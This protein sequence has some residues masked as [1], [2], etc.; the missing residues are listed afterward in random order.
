MTLLNTSVLQQSDF[1]QS[2]ANSE[3]VVFLF[4]NMALSSIVRLSTSIDFLVQSI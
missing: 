3:I 2:L 4:Y 1:N